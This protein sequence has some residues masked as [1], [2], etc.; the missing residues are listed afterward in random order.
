MKNQPGDS[1]SSI[2]VSVHWKRGEPQPTGL[3]CW[4]EAQEARDAHQIPWAVL[5]RRARA[6]ILDLVK[7]AGFRFSETG[8][9]LTEQL[10]LL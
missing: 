2:G 10:P 4:T 7:Y 8:I 5:P 3:I 6:Q 1:P 9:E